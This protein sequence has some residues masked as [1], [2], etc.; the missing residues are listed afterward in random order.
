MRDYEGDMYPELENHGGYVS[1]LYHRAKNVGITCLSAAAA[2][3]TF[4]HLYT[5]MLYN[6]LYLDE[7]IRAPIVYGVMLLSTD[8]YFGNFI[9]KCL[10]KPL[11]W[12][13]YD[14]E[15]SLIK[16]Y[17]PQIVGLGAGAG[18][19]M[20]EIIGVSK[21]VDWLIPHSW[22]FLGMLED[23]VMD[24]FVGVLFKPDVKDGESIAQ[25]IKQ[26][27]FIGK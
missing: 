14:Y 18:W 27:L 24:S 17:R 16:K 21:I 15:S 3:Y 22:S 12:L 19:E 26:R 4:R 7:K 20:S 9:D 8:K 13:G 10:S 25:R 6:G 23:F 2:G 5:Q 11:G 1:N